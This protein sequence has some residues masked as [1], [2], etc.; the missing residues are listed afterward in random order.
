MKKLLL[1]LLLVSGLANAQDFDSMTREERLAYVAKAVDDIGAGQADAMDAYE[2]WHATRNPETINFSWKL[3]DAGTQNGW[4]YLHVQWIDTCDSAT[5]A[6]FDG[7]DNFLDK[8][9]ISLDFGVGKTL[10]L[11]A[12]VV[13]RAKYA[14]IKCNN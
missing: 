7:D 10:I 6:L 1:G 11:N 8:T 14:K 13:R 3:V 12:D 2:E 9:Y 4:A 5:I